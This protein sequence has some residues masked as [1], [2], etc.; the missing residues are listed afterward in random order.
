MKK[1]LTFLYCEPDK[2][3][4]PGR[5]AFPPS[6]P[7]S[8]IVS[9]QIWQGRK[10]KSGNLSKIT[11]E[12]TQKLRTFFFLHESWKNRLLQSTT[13]TFS[14]VSRGRDKFFFKNSSWALVN[15]AL[16]HYENTSSSLPDNENGLRHG[17]RRAGGAPVFFDR[18]K[19]GFRFPGTGH[20]RNSSGEDSRFRAILVA[21][22]QTKSSP[23]TSNVESGLHEP[24]HGVAAAQV[25][26]YPDQRGG[27]R[28]RNHQHENLDPFASAGDAPN[29]S[30][31]NPFTKEYGEPGG[32]SDNP[33]AS[34]YFHGHLRPVWLGPTCPVHGANVFRGRQ[35]RT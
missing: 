17:N 12:G 27:G 4:K 15:V 35:H 16:S 18:H 13:L 22:R 33:T 21:T 31:R 6:L 2:V 1:R 10:K 32:I 3:T 11:Y 29:L 26:A 5:S 24:E 28:R 7:P 34:L 19:P 14:W 23:D 8:F 25:H 30:A 20:R 9:Q